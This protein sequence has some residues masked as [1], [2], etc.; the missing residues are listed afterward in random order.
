MA[1]GLAFLHFA[2]TAPSRIPQ[3]SKKGRGTLSPALA[4]SSSSEQCEKDLRPIGIVNV[5]SWSLRRLR[6]LIQQLRNG[7]VD[8]VIRLVGAIGD[9]GTDL[10]D[11][12]LADVGNVVD[13]R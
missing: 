3:R 1:Q 7:N 2:F 8:F 11:A 6:D 4:Y 9:L 10:I 13:P 12:I 5:N